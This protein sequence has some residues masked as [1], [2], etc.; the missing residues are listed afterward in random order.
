MKIFKFNRI[1]LLKKIDKINDR[2]PYDS[3]QYV[4]CTSSLYNSEKN[5]H[6]KKSYDN[7]TKLEF[8]GHEFKTPGGYD[9]ILR[10]MYGDYMKLPPKAE[11][12]THHSNKVYIKEI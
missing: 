12:V 8:E 2:Y 6:N 5:R 9:E 1:N 7:Y 11:Q 10:Q 4:G 3:A